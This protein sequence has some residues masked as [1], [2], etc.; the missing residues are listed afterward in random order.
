ML[1]VISAGLDRGNISIIPHWVEPFLPRV[2]FRRLIELLR[3]RLRTDRKS[4]ADAMYWMPQWVPPNDASAK[5]LVELLDE[6][7]N[8]A[9][10]GPR[11]GA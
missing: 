7:L 9:Q 11:S 6:E 1:T 10:E 2:G 8:A 4:V 3:R 5:R